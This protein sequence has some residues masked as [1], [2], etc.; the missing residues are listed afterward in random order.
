MFH[1]LGQIEIIFHLEP[2]E[3]SVRIGLYPKYEVAAKRTT[4]LYI[5]DFPKSFKHSLLS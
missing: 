2:T 4:L 1:L 3:I 5:V